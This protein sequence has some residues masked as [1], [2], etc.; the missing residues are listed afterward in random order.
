MSNK[1]NMIPSSLQIELVDAPE[2]QPCWNT[3]LNDYL[4]EDSHFAIQ[5]EDP[6]YGYAFE[7]KLCM[8]SWG[9]QQEVTCCTPLLFQT[10]TLMPEEY[11]DSP[12]GKKGYSGLA[13]DPYE[14]SIA[15]AAEEDNLSI[16][17]LEKE[18][19]E[20]IAPVEFD[21]K[22]EE[23]E[24]EIKKPKKKKLEDSPK[25]KAKRHKHVGKA[26]VH[27]KKAHLACDNE[28]PCRRCVHLG[29]TDCVD[30]EHKRRGRPRTSPEKKKVIKPSYKQP[31]HFFPELF[32]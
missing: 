27:C 21:L 10:H 13:G 1:P 14:Y 12:Q 19:P 16:D 6:L 23:L 25:D 2:E 9:F 22:D 5:R 3:S 8:E 32:E 11:Y 30:V 20:F 18:L 7:P 17:L 26:C 29:K 28:R 31:R 24:G 15:L 4:V